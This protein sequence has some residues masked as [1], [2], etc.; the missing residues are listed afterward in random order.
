MM[1]SPKEQRYAST[2][3]QGVTVDGTATP[4][5]PIL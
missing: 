4:K 2:K 1:H 5:N 3:K